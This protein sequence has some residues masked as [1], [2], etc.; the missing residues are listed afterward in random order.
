MLKFCKINNLSNKN[1]RCILFVA[2]CWIAGIMIGI[3]LAG[4]TLTGNNV[5]RSTELL[6]DISFGWNLLVLSIPVFL[7]FWFIRRNW[8]PAVLILI[9]FKAFLCGFTYTFVS[10]YFGDCAWL[11]RPFLLFGSSCSSVL[12]WYMVFTHIFN[13]AYMRTHLALS[14]SLIL[15]GISLAN[16]FLISP[17][18]ERLIPYF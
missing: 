15:L 6:G 13:Q 9:F 12:I 16:I 4:D 11:I 17:F 8:I 2:L 5:A 7:L 10:R 1:M 18:L 14:Y 3:I